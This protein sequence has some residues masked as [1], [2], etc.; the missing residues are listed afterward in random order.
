MELVLPNNY[1]ALEEEEMMYLD[2]GLSIHNSVV[3]FG[4]NSAVNTVIAY[5]MGGGG[6]FALF[7]AAIKAV[8]RQT[9]TRRLKGALINFLGVQAANRISGIVVGFILETGGLSVGGMLAKLWDSGD[10]HP[11]NGWCDII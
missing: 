7:K 6:G 4:V 8:G 1:V 10:K 11:N 9:F 2:G 3:A 5:F